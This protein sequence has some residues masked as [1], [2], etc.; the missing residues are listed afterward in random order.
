MIAVSLRDVTIRYGDFEA[1]AHVSADF[2]AGAVG[3]LGRNGAG[4]TSILKA[5][6]GLVRPTSGTLTI[7][8]VPEGATAVEL[9]RH[10]G[11]MPENEG[12][13]RLYH[14]AGF[15]EE[16]SDED[17]EIIARFTLAGRR[18]RR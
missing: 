17:G 7:S 11:Y 3:L 12:A 5:L 13:R 18:R 15:V 6:L 9:R 14:S 4:K 16:G 8:G 10:V 1:V 2:P